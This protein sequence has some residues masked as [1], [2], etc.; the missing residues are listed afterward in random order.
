LLVVVPSLAS[1]GNLTLSPGSVDFGEVRVGQ[2]AIR[3]ARVINHGAATTI[4]GIDPGGSCFDF[5]ASAALPTTLFDLDTLTITITYTPGSRGPELCAFE[6]EDDNGVSTLLG[7]TG[8][9]VASRLFIYETFVPFGMQSWNSAVPETIHIACE[10]FGNLA[11]GSSDFSAQFAIGTD[12][13]LGEMSFPIP[14]GGLGDIPLV[15]HPTSI[16]PKVDEVTFSVDNDLPGDPNAVLELYGVWNSV[17]SVGDRTPLPDG[18]RIGPSPTRGDVTIRYSP[19]KPGRV[20]IEIRDVAGRLVARR[21]EVAPGTGPQTVT[22]R[23]P[24]EWSPAPGVYLVSVS[25]EGKV[26]GRGR[27]VV[28]K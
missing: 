19:P 1:G 20:E 11:I 7:A 21:S 27:V 2:S 26:L 14:A 4:T 25:L 3:T 9:G 28:V 12:F 18:F 24:S 15:F 17:T 23:G 5:Q 16:G 22:F 10:N 6:L 8:I 13:H